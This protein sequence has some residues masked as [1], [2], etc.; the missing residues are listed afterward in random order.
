VADHRLPTG[1]RLP[2]I[3]GALAALWTCLASSATAQARFDVVTGDK[4]G[5]VSG[6][7]VYTIRDKQTATCYTLFVLDAARGGDSRLPALPPAPELSSDQLDKVRLAETLRDLQAERDRELSDLQARTNNLWVF[8]Y[9]INRAQIEQDYE[10]AVIHL[11]PGLYPSAQVAP[12][13]P[14]SSRGEVD[15]AV[16][17]AM[18]EGDA[19]TSRSAVDE[20]LLTLLEHFAASQGLA[21]VTSVSGPVP[22]PAAK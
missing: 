18:A 13:L 1:V 8:D 2:A 12:G 4:V 21:P 15:A 20:R 22:C 7:D 5:G 6:L 9:E 16:S 10:N 3:L 11:L 14:T 17:R 19:I